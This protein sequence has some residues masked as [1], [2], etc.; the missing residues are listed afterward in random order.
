MPLKPPPR[1]QQNSQDAPDVGTMPLAGDPG[2]SPT[3]SQP[4][5]PGEADPG[6]LDDTRNILLITAAARKLATK[7]PSAVP[8]VQTIN[9]AVQKLQMKIM[10]VQPPAQVPTPPQ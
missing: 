3:N 9:D 1:L 10:M 8:E 4:T 7:Y 5:G 6:A 2:E